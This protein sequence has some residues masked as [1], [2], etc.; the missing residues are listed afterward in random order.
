MPV[1]VGPS[2]FGVERFA[3]PSVLDL[4]A[5]QHPDRVML[6]IAGTSVTFAQ[7]RDRSCAAGNVLHIKLGRDITDTSTATVRVFNVSFT[8][9]RSM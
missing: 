9:R 4:R 2:A 5:E 3:V 6:S 7:M 1:G 8:I